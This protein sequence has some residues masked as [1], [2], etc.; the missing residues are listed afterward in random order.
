MAK[1]LKQTIKD[2]VKD[3]ESTVTSDPLGRYTTSTVHRGIDIG[4]SSGTHLHDG[5]SGPSVGDVGFWN[6]TSW[7]SLAPTTASTVD[8]TTEFVKSWANKI[9]TEDNDMIYLRKK[10]GILYVM[11]AEVHTSGTWNRL[12]PKD[13]PVIIDVHG[14][15]L[16]EKLGNPDAKIVDATTVEVKPEEPVI[17]N[18][19][20]GWYQDEKADLFYY[21]GEG[22]WREVDLKTNKKLTEMVLAGTLEFIG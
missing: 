6:G 16:E 22:H 9:A 8:L 19:P 18:A 21:E 15:T 12:D 1:T 11:K 13:E 17:L 10:N 14:K 4:T 7:S 2:M 5:S 3:I 20:I